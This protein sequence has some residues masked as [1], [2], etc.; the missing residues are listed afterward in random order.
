MTSKAAV[1]TW[2][3]SGCDRTR[4]TEE[5]GSMQPLSQQ[6]VKQEYIGKHINT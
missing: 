5:E 4:K 6:E 2:R 1:A 3:P